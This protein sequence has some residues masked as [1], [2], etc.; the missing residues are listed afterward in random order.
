MA[1]LSR[2]GGS[3]QLPDGHCPHPSN[4]NPIAFILQNDEDS[5]T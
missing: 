4:Q 5:S 1:G 3:I 2:L